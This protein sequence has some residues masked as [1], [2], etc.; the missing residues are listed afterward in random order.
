MSISASEIPGPGTA[1]ALLAAVSIYTAGI[2]AH[3]SDDWRKLFFAFAFAALV[4]TLIIEYWS[5]NG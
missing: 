3:L 5:H 4:V 2:P 1:T